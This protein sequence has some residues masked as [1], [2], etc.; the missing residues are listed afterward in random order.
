MLMLCCVQAIGTNMCLQNKSP[1]LVVLQIPSIFYYECTAN[2]YIVECI[3]S[4]FYCNFL[5]HKPAFRPE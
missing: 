2:I 5:W 1:E 3:C 4:V